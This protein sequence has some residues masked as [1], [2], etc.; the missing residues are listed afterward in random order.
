MH[1][2][3]NPAI[4]DKSIFTNKSITPNDNDLIGPLGNTCKLWH[5]IEDYVHLKYPKAFDEWNF[6]GE[7]YGWSFR[8]KDKKRTIIYFLPRDQF[9][10]VAFVYGQKA[11]DMIVKSNVSEWIK[12]ELESARV[13]AEGR[14]IRLEIRDETILDDIKALVDIKLAN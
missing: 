12:K 2:I 7:K 14:G 1:K 9:F 3:Q 13:Y 10:K 11:T 6:S 5:L 8:I 4:M